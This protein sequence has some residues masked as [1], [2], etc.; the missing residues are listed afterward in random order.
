MDTKLNAATSI[1]KLFTPLSGPVLELFADILIRTELRKNELLFKEGEVSDQIGY[2]Y[3]GMVRQFYFKNNKDLT[4][5][6]TCN[7]N[8]FI[9]IESFLKQVPRPLK[10]EAIE[11]SIIYGIPYGPLEKLS[12][13]YFEIEYLYR[14]MLE[15]SLILSQKKADSLRF[16][17]A[18]ERYE[19]LIKTQPEIIKRAPLSQ[20][21][22]LLEMTP[23]TLSRVR[24]GNF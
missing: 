7:G 24:G 9:C 13:Q 19:R 4:E 20:I 15:S 16:E 6:F 18:R 14:K 12:R 1:S 17:S 8:L 10:V 21:A 23:E 5:H 2:V 3:K 22:S 11:P